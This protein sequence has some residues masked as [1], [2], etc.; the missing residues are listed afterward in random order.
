MHTG[1]ID[2]EWTFGAAVRFL[3]CARGIKLVLEGLANR[4][5]HHLKNDLCGSSCIIPIGQKAEEPN[6]NQHYK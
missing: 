1:I 4:N 6:Y 3:L 5:L 2:L